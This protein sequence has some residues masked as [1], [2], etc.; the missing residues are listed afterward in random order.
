MGGSGQ[1]ADHD[2]GIVGGH[3]RVYEAAGSMLCWG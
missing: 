1:T 2:M 3:V